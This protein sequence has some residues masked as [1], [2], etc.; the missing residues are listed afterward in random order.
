MIAA[1]VEEGIGTGAGA[2]A[3]AVFKGTVTGA[4]VSVR[5]T[6]AAGRTRL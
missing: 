6:D 4:R 5:R 3:G 2:G 1:V